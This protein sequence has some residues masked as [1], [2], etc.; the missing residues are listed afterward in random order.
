M[1][2]DLAEHV[3]VDIAAGMGQADFLALELIPHLQ[4]RG[5]SGGA[6]ALCQVMRGREV[7][8]HRLGDLIV[9]DG[10]DLVREFEDRRDIVAL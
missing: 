4:G 2:Q 5:E 1:L 6:G 8:A 7:Q 9:G 10:D 3:G